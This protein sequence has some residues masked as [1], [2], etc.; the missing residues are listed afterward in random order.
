MDLAFKRIFRSMVR[1]RL[2]V[3]VIGISFMGTAVYLSWMFYLS[4]VTSPMEIMKNIDKRVIALSQKFASSDLE[5]NHSLADFSALKNGTRFRGGRWNATGDDGMGRLN[6]IYPSS[7]GGGA[8]LQVEID[9]QIKKLRSDLNK[10]TEAQA[11]LDKKLGVAVSVNSKS[12]ILD[13]AKTNAGP[14]SAVRTKFVSSIRE[15]WKSDRI[16]DSL[17]YFEPTSTQN[18]A[19]TVDEAQRLANASL[20]AKGKIVGYSNTYR[21][22]KL[23]T[24]GQIFK[25]RHHY[26]DPC[27]VQ[28]IIAI[29]A[30]IMFWW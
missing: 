10:L 7:G 28:Q 30:H 11:F 20:T 18:V 9:I 14:D 1:S 13:R 21:D 15:T 8:Q 17:Q 26:P 22:A 16:I 23:Q 25:Y 29:D 19:F 5:R 4:A 2:L 24:E 3:W 27:T 6:S 12:S